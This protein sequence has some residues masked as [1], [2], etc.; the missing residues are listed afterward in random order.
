MFSGSC[1]PAFRA[2][3]GPGEGWKWNWHQD[4]GL[5][6]SMSCTPLTGGENK[7]NVRLVARKPSQIVELE[8]LK[9]AIELEL[10]RLARELLSNASRKFSWVQKDLPEPDK[11]AAVECEGQLYLVTLP[12]KKSKRESLGLARF[13]IHT[14]QGVAVSCGLVALLNNTTLILAPI[15]GENGGIRV[16]IDNGHSNVRIVLEPKEGI[17]AEYELFPRGVDDVPRI[18]NLVNSALHKDLVVPPVEDLFASIAD[19]PFVTDSDSML[20]K[21]LDSSPLRSGTM[22]G[23]NVG[24]PE[25]QWS[26]LLA[27]SQH[28]TKKNDLFKG[29]AP[30]LLFSNPWPFLQTSTSTGDNLRN[31]ANSC[32]GNDLA[33]SKQYANV[34]FPNEI[35]T[36]FPKSGKHSTG[37]ENIF[38]NTFDAK[39]ST[40][41]KSVDQPT[42]MPSALFDGP[43]NL[44]LIPENS[45]TILSTLPNTLF[46]GELN[47]NVGEDASGSELV[48]HSLTEPGKKRTVTFHAHLEKQ[49]ISS[50]SKLGVASEFEPMTTEPLTYDGD[51]ITEE[52]LSSMDQSPV[53]EII[54][55]AVICTDE[56]N[57]DDHLMQTQPNAFKIAPL[58]NK[59]LEPPVDSE[60]VDTE[61]EGDLPL[62]LQAVTPAQGTESL[63]LPLINDSQLRGLITGNNA[64]PAVSSRNDENGTNDLHYLTSTST[65]DESAMVTNE[66]PNEANECGDFDHPTSTSLQEVAPGEPLILGLPKDDCAIPSQFQRVSQVEQLSANSAHDLEF[67]LAELKTNLKEVRAPH[68]T[69]DAFSKS[70]GNVSSETLV[71]G[72]HVG[73]VEPPEGT[74]PSMGV[75][76]LT[77]RILELET[78]LRSTESQL[79]HER[80]GREI[81]EHEADANKIQYLEMREMLW[82]LD[83]RYQALLSDFRKVQDELSWRRTIQSARSKN[84][85]I[86]EKVA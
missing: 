48:K 26:L 84:D 41:F 10:D 80:K 39:D 51:D 33:S 22:I 42:A 12:N 50:T 21:S 19:N 29:V 59:C 70:S 43:L 15:T 20:P 32:E 71:S 52:D 34:L 63:Q 6:L 57:T 65:C 4:G 81:A 86:I 69:Y 14:L 66:H 28:L 13:A 61:D 16:L 45:V 82:A 3:V 30:P 76:N 72:E 53:E 40:P 36:K 83:H 31:P 23:N 75:V 64:I 49:T 37:F 55:T 2:S 74:T 18:A 56:A 67:T 25:D 54:S 8:R 38:P 68:K 78:S 60:Y 1:R 9:E 11:H 5:D 77:K 58:E 46:D 47:L 7:C 17:V 62:T 79:S 24:V 35:M 44:S 73:K 27:Q 85:Q